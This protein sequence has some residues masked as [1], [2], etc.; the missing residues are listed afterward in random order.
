MGMKITL[1]C[2][3]M[4]TLKKLPQSLHFQRQV[5]MTTFRRVQEVQIVRE[6]PKVQIC[7][8]VLTTA[9][10]LHSVDAIVSFFAVSSPQ[11]LCLWMRLQP[12]MKRRFWAVEKVLLLDAT[13]VENLW[14]N[15]YSLKSAA[16][17]CHQ[18]WALVARLS[19]EEIF[20][21]AWSAY[22][23]FFVILHTW[24]VNA[25]NFPKWMRRHTKCCFLL[26]VSNFVKGSMRGNANCVAK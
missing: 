21:L 24:P 8:F 14:K 2:A 16:Q 13:G 15:L 7:T 25:Y 12:T 4:K 22:L 5:Q 23:S 1:Q 6:H 19:A 10:P 26:I 18:R 20:K 9:Q 17:W 3:L 11:V